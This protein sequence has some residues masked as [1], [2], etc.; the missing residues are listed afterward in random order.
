MACVRSHGH[1]RS[2]SLLRESLHCHQ[3]KS[4]NQPRLS[5]WL[6]LLSQ[7]IITVIGERWKRSIAPKS[8][9]FIPSFTSHQWMSHYH[10]NQALAR[11]M[12]TTLGRWTGIAPTTTSK[13]QCW[14]NYCTI[15]I[16]PTSMLQCPVLV[17]RWSTIS[18]CWPSVAPTIVQKTRY[19]TCTL[20][21][22]Q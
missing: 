16:Q 10:L 6:P 3:A 14:P 13:T 19:A 7:V 22:R 1:P 4:G 9:A 5:N 21:R 8:S 18:R 2:Q 17:Q 20:T 11:C 15:W 12:S